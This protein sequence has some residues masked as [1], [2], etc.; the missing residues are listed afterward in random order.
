MEATLVLLTSEQYGFGPRQNSLLFAY[1]GLMIVFVQG[2]LI[3]RLSKNTAKVS[4][5]LSALC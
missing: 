2:G 1:I 5:L 3:H 4:L